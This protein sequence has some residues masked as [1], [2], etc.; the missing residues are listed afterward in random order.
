HIDARQIE[1]LK[2]DFIVTQSHCE[3]CAVSDKNLGTLPNKPKVLSLQSNV[4]DDLWTNMERVGQAFHVEKLAH[5]KIASLKRRVHRVV[6]TCKNVPS[7]PRVA[8]IEWIDPLMG[9]GNWI[10]EL[11]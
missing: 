2:P 7:R 8:A 11:I 10:P 4:F 9:A 3:V 6:E 5:E 1:Q